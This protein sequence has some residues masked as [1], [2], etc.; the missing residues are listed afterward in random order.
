MERKISENRFVKDFIDHLDKENEIELLEVFLNLEDRSPAFDSIDE[1]VFDEIAKHEY[2]FVDLAANDSVDYLGLARHLNAVLFTARSS[3]Y[4]ADSELSYS[5]LP[6]VDGGYEPVGIKSVCDVNSAEEILEALSL[7]SGEG[8]IS[9]IL[10]FC[11][12]TEDFSGWYEGLDKNN[13]EIVRRRLIYADQK[14]FQ[15]GKPLF[16]TL[17]NADGMREIRMKAHAGGAIRI[18]FGIAQTGKQA[19]LRAWIKKADNEGYKTNIAA[20]KLVWDGLKK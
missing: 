16:D 1:I 17:N 12:L 18:L 13:K 15:G 5:I 19:I 4:W 20:A 7:F 2:H 9:E 10:K 14:R 3:E 11:F 8:H 6:S